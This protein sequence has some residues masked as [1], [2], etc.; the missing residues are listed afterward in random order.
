VRP[1]RAGFYKGEFGRI[2]GP[3]GWS[4]YQRRVLDEALRWM[5]PIDQPT[6]RKLVVELETEVEQERG[7]K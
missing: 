4:E 7:E 5:E 2:V 3:P 1:P 6:V